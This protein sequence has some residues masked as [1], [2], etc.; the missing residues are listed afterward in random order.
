MRKLSKP[1]CIVILLS[2]ITGLYVVKKGNAFEKRKTEWSIGI[3]VGSSP[4]NLTSPKG[5]SNPVLTASHVT[6]IEAKFV[7]DPFMVI[8]NS[9]CYMFFEVLNKNTNQ[10]DI[11]LATSNDGRTWHYRKIVIDEPFHLSYPY[12]FKWK[13]EYYLMPESYED[14]S[15][16]MY[17]ATNFPAEWEFVG[18]LLTGS[19]FVDPSIFRFRDKWWLFFTSTKSDILRLYFAAYLMRPWVEHPESPIIEKNPNISR[20]GGRVLVVNDRIF[21]FAQDDYPTYG[22]QVTAFEITELTTVSYKEKAVAEGPILSASGTGWNAKCMHHIDPHPLY[23]K[24]WI[25]CVDGKGP[26]VVFG[27]GY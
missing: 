2:L 16:R 12:V 11:G 22:N 6:D 18:T 7:A 13:G 19:D 4:F 17:K 26:R 20:P 23:G 21:R 15:I 9:T 25:A 8:E 24:G 10:G 1:L 3:Y 27:F 14:S 5:V